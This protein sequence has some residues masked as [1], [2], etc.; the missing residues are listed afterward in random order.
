MCLNCGAVEDFDDWPP[1][2]WDAL[3]TRVHTFTNSLERIDT[4]TDLITTPVFVE[5]AAHPKPIRIFDAADLYDG[6]YYVDD[7]VDELEDN[8]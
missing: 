8:R 5:P 1:N 6:I 3:K 4:A 7:E 2:E